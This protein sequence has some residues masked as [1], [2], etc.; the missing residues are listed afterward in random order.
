MHLEAA[1]FQQATVRVPTGGH[2]LVGVVEQ[3]DVAGDP[4]CGKQ[5]AQR[6]PARH[7][8]LARGDSIVRY[9]AAESPL[10]ICESHWRMVAART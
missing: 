9:K 5:F 1:P 3:I 8:A 10:E 6:R 2:R 7:V 4:R